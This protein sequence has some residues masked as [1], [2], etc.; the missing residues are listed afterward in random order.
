MLCYVAPYC[1]VLLEHAEIS[2]VAVLH[3][4]CLRSSA[5]AQLFGTL[6]A[7]M[8]PCSYRRQGGAD[9]LQPLNSATVCIQWLRVSV[10][11]TSACRRQ[12]GADRLWPVQAPAR[13][14][15][16][17]LCAAGAHFA[18]CIWVATVL[19]FAVHVRKLP[20]LCRAA[21]TQL[22]R[23]SGV[24]CALPSL[25]ALL[26]RG[27]THSKRLSNSYRNWFGPHSLYPL[28]VLALDKGREDE[29]AAALA[30]IGVVT[31]KEDPALKVRAWLAGWLAGWL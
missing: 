6:D 26:W 5:A 29:I 28:Q 16:R 3:R 7:N 11:F 15:P 2:V 20:G 30:G 27:A 19:W 21:V 9:R 4:E 31:E 14:I 24:C 25:A 12:G 23:C 22:A 8:R 10:S 18:A 17:R 1:A 13:L